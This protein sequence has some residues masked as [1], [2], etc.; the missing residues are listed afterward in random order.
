MGMYKRFIL[1]AVI[2]SIFSSSLF[3]GVGFIFAEDPTPTPT[4]TSNNS[5]AISDL[6][7]KI[8]DLQNKIADTQK[9]EKTLSS[10]ISV[11]DNQVRLTEFR[12]ESTKQDI[13]NLTED[14]ETA[15]KKIST[16]EASL[17]NLTKVLLNRVV[18]TYQAGSADPIQ[19][20]MLS[21]NA[22]ELF[23]RMN[24]LKLIQAHDKELLLETQQAKNDYANQKTIFEDKKKKV[25]S[26]KA[27]LEQYTKQLEADK[28]NKKNLLAQTQGSE[29][30]YQRLLAE[31]K[32]QLARFSNF[33]TSQG[34]ASILSNQTSCDDWG[35]YYNQRDS[36]W[37]TTALNNTGY[38][39]ASDG[40]LV[41]SMAM[42]YTHYGHRDVNPQSI[43]S[44]S[45]NFSGIPA[46]LL[47]KSIVANGTS[48]QRIGAEID[49]TLDSGH[50]IIIG[51]SYDGGYWP[52]HFVVFIKKENGDYKMNDPFTPNGHNISFRDRYPG[53]RIVE[54]DKVIF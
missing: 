32:A 50:P 33:T 8:N 24:Y 9:Q 25:E 22:S 46:A 16:L 6:Q 13:D 44:V 12:I 7:S 40:C 34:G 14:I 53:V 11:M 41:T 29:A 3:F 51:I 39:I 30:T 43:N 27:Q 54:I 23:T 15:T 2:I 19:Q 31:T 10:Q 47:K 4:P 37:G 20:F 49:S 48:S 42:V 28:Q 35:C 17:D 21:D 36:Q 52:D 5:Q 1:L 38:T 18:A 26:L 45:E